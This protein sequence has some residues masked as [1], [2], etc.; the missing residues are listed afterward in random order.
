[1]GTAALVLGGIAAGSA[2]AGT[3]YNMYQGQQTASAASDE[4]NRAAIREAQA[5]AKADQQQAMIDKKRKEADKAAAERQQ[6][7]ASNGLL[8]GSETGVDDFTPSLLA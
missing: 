2:V 7:M 4:R 8:S 3:A 5:Q 6:R 1:M